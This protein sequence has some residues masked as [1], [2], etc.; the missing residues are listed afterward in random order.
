MILL[1]G[2]RLLAEPQ[3]L[4]EL[5]GRRRFGVVLPAPLVLRPAAGQV[6][7]H[8]PRQTLVEVDRQLVV[9][10]DLERTLVGGERLVMAGEL[11]ERVAAVG[12][13]VGEVGAQLQRPI[14]GG[15][16]LV[17]AVELLQDQ[18]AV[19]ERFGEVG[20]Q[21]QRPIER[22]QRLRRPLQVAQRQA[23]VV[24]QVEVV[25]C[26]RA[27]PLESSERLVEASSASRRIR[28]LSIQA[29]VSSGASCSARS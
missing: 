17:E 12:M 29:A 2:E 9:L 3:R 23:E 14:V 13:G 11:L 4:A 1:A 21:L 22:R 6:A 28:P 7:E 8:Q 18:A 15:E 25:R 24:E 10:L 26:G 20:L 27:R 5:P 19:A 16:R